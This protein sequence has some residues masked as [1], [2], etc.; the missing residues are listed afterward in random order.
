MPAVPALGL[1]L[2]V[3][4]ELLDLARS[5]CVD[6]IEVEPQTLWEKVGGSGGW[7]YVPNERLVDAIAEVGR[8]ALIHGIGHPLGGTVRDPIEHLALLKSMADRLDARWVSEHL[9]FNRVLEAGSVDET[10]FLMPPRQSPAGARVAAARIADF[11][12]AMGLPTAFELGVNYLSPEHDALDDGA[13]FTTVA[14]QSDAGILLDLHNLWC[15]ERN[16]RSTVLEVIDALPLDRVW[17][18][19][20][21][22][23][24]ELDGYTLDAHSGRVPD[25]VLA[26]AAEIIPRLP[27][28]G[29]VIFEILPEHLPVLGLD[30]VADELD[31]LR[32]LWDLAPR[33]GDEPDEHLG[34]AD[35][36]P[37]AVLIT[38]SASDL[39][40]V[41]AWERSV[42]GAVRGSAPVDP[43]FDALPHDPGTA[44]LRRL[45]DEF[46]AS[47]LTRALRYTIIA[48]LARLGTAA[49]HDVM[50]EYFAATPPDGFRAVECHQF[51]MYLHERDDVLAQVPYL[52]EVLAFERALIEA[53]LFESSTTVVWSADPTTILESLER[54]A[55]PDGLPVETVAMVVG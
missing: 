31:R 32:P 6:V 47:S 8:P 35:V 26:L 49:T 41:A 51:A 11:R 12:R 48:M 33:A 40:E 1:G 55:L 20:L 23:G 30:G 34:L 43:R 7:R 28:L 19:H 13:Y 9:S 37:D 15:N 21:A 29:A 27:N 42:D 44:L 14:E 4:G 53:T 10:G 24:M 2:V 5:G 52:A 36:R 50:N 39:D 46:R 38:P 18:V 45:V 54:G 16:G 25:E 17:E 22:G 3:F